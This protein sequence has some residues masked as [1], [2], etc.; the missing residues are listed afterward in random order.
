[1][2]SQLLDPGQRSLHG[3]AVQLQSLGE[4]RERGFGYVAATLGDDPHDVGLRSE[5]TVGLELADGLEL[6]SRGG[7]GSLEIGRFGV[8]DAI[9]VAADGA[10]DLPR[11]EFQ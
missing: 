7:N 4:F 8:D 6:A 9:Q 5:A 11:F 2:E 3:G 10:R 1:V